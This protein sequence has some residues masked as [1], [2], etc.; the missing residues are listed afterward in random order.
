MARSRPTEPAPTPPPGFLASAV[1]LPTAT[2]NMAGRAEGWQD[3]AWAYWES[4]GELRYVSTWIGNVMS[5]AR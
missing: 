1:R 5:R 2:R 3:E 4:V